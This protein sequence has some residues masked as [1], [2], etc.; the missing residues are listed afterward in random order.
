MMMTKK[1][2]VILCT[3]YSAHWDHM[4]EVNTTDTV[5]YNEH[6]FDSTGFLAKFL[7]TW[8]TW[9]TPFIKLPFQ[10]KLIYQCLGFITDNDTVP[11]CI[12]FIVVP[13]QL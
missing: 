10:L 12:L 2:S 8:G 11:E 4:A 1:H 6:H 9:M 3:E 13:F 7:W 5:I